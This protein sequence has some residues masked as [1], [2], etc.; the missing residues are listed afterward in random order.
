MPLLP[1]KDLLTASPKLSKLVRRKQFELAK[2][3][4]GKVGLVRVRDRDMQRLDENLHTHL[5]SPPAS[6]RPFAITPL[7]DGSRF[8]VAPGFVRV[9][10]RPGVT[11]PLVDGKP[12]T[13]T[14][15]TLSGH[16]YACVQVKLLQTSRRPT[17]RVYSG[18]TIIDSYPATVHLMAENYVDLAEDPVIVFAGNQRG[19]LAVVNGDAS[20]GTFGTYLIP[21]AYV[22]PSGIVRQF[23]EHNL[24]ITLHG[25]F[26]RVRR[27][28]G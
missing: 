3:Q 6:T 23:I 11:W 9:P 16:G 10:T 26:L 7:G 18:P 22:S 17:A 1:F 14:D 19:T 21:L 25:A 8:A 27:I 5:P 4:L 12:I 20:T 13:R 2:R 15:A 24:E 28:G